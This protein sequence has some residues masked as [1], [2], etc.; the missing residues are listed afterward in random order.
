MGVMLADMTQLIVIA[1]KTQPLL[2]CIG[3]EITAG[4]MILNITQLIVLIL[5]TQPWLDF[6]IKE[7]RSD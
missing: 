2:D 3:K 1:L 7:Q 6:M 4:V 5:K